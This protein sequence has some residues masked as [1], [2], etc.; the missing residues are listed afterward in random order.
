MKLRIGFSVFLLGF[1]SGAIADQFSEG[2]TN[3]TPLRSSKNLLTKNSQQPSILSV[4]LYL[5]LIDDAAWP[6]TLAQSQLTVTPTATYLVR[7]IRVT[8]WDS[9]NGSCTTLNK[10][11]TIDNGV[12]VTVPLVI[13]HAYQTTDASNWALKVIATTGPQVADDTYQ[14]LDNNLNPIGASV[15]IPGA[16]MP[17]NTRCNSLTNCGWN[18]PRTWAP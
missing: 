7:A 17:N 1:C 14:L 9:N 10:V 11:I 13:N 3:G 6:N 5:T 2:E 4:P 16:P 8:Y 12:G 15:C 18:S